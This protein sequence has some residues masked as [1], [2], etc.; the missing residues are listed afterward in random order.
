MFP[1]RCSSGATCDPDTGSCSDSICQEGFPQT[2]LEP[3]LYSWRG[4]GCQIGNVAYKQPTYQS[5][6]GEIDSSK[7]VDG[8]LGDLGQGESCANPVNKEG[9]A[10]WFYVDLQRIHQMYNV[11]L[12]NTFNVDVRMVNFSIQVGNFSDID[13]H[14]RCAYYEK[15]VLQGGSVTLEC[16]AKA[17]Y[18]SFR[19]EG[20]IQVNRVTICE[21]VVIGY[22]LRSGGKT[23]SFCL[24]GNVAYG[25]VTEQSG[26]WGGFTSNYG[27]DGRLGSS[28]AHLAN[29]DGLAAW[30]C[31]DLGSL[32]KIFNVVLYN[33]EYGSEFQRMKD[34]SIRGG[35]FSDI[36]QQTEC[37]YYGETVQA[38]QSVTIECQ[39]T[40]RYVSFRREG[41]NTI[42]RVTICEFIVIG[43]PMI[44]RGNGNN[45]NY[46]IL[47][48]CPSKRRGPLCLYD[49]ASLPFSPSINTSDSI[50]AQSV[51]C[52]N[53]KSNIDCNQLPPSLSGTTVDTL[54]VKSVDTTSIM[55]GTAI[56]ECS[57]LPCISID[58]PS[59]A[60]STLTD[61]P[62]E[63]ACTSIDKACVFSSESECEYTADEHST[64]CTGG[65]SYEN[66]G[67]SGQPEA[68]P[69]YLCM[70][71][72][73]S[74]DETDLC[75][76]H[77][78]QVIDDSNI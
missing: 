58:E 52:F 22:P 78:Y 35:N 40:A 69:D 51:N 41:G 4:P 18:V 55:T 73:K 72:N 26:V 62:S 61:K 37:A 66:V 19:K 47:S 13:R 15:T 44:T 21:F 70:E 39:V 3:N 33:A 17:R 60:T 8:I 57:A 59:V 34:F 9:E 38:G 56:G 45:I 36:N 14:T 5:Y 28:C 71:M 30:Y 25:K 23:G 68:D 11:T 31:V 74:N 65:M 6:F 77:I 48:D 24:D 49:E 12:Y 53:R 16:E 43:H 20:D 46:D 67:F 32:H 1:C 54:S 27:V 7:G 50:L 10:V 42:N 64:S 63:V 2:P 76:E 75:I 29:L